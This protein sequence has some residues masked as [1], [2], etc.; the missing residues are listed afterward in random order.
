VDLGGERRR[1]SLIGIRG[2]TMLIDLCRRWFLSTPP[3]A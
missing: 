3:S 2:Q 1:F